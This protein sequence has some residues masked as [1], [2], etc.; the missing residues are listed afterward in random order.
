MPKCWRFEHMKPV[1]LA[2]AIKT[3]PIAYLVVSP[4]EWHGEAMAFGCDPAIG[5]KVAT[6]A[7]ERTGGVLF[8]T[9]YYGA[10]TLFRE[11][12]D[13]GWVDHWGME[14]RTKEH[15][16]GSIYCTPG[17]LE[18]MVKETLSFI[19]HE[20]FRVCALVSGHGGREHVAVFR[21]LERRWE[22]R[23]MKLLYSRRARRRRR[24]KS[25]RFEG[26]GGHADF[27]EASV[28]GAVDP[29][30]VD[31]RKFGRIRRDRGIG[32]KHENVHLID[33]DKGKR[34]L[35]FRIAGLARAVREA[36][37]VQKPS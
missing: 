15:H 32:L 23:P 12:V 4:L 27:S 37:K 6:E 35:E 7:W 26:S 14:V 29:T 8:P 22:G 36:L 11:W 34:V 10:E 30:M 28:L 3:R 21:D 5:T 18:L 24:P 31:K 20:G 19:E 1:D 17:T 33:Y 9:M 2:K 25:L 16:P 13:D